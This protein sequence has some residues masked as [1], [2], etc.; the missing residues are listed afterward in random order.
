M[1]R[2]GLSLCYEI[3]YIN[4]GIITEKEYNKAKE[5]IIQRYD[6]QRFPDITALGKKVNPARKVPEE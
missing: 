5:I 3:I 4:Y 6:N 1:A 2:N